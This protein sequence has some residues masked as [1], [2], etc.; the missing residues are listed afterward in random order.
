MDFFIHILFAI[1]FIAIYVMA[2]ILIKPFRFNKKRKIS[3]FCLKTSYL[4]YLFFLLLYI[5]FM[6]F[7]QE[8]DW[9]DEQ[10]ST[11]ETIIIMFVCLI[12]NFAIIA[13]REFQA[14][15][16]LYNFFFSFV[17]LICAIYLFLDIINYS[18]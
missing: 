9:D 3:T 16:N 8:Y 14:Y 1:T 11:K 12:P 15:R 17:N 10:L 18:Y 13:R 2:F 4:V 6:I 7:F 5:Y